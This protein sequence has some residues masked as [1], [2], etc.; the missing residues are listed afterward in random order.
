M[1]RGRYV[2]KEAWH[3]RRRCAWSLESGSA[4]A[5]KRN[6]RNLMHILNSLHC[7]NNLL[8]KFEKVVS[9]N[10]AAMLANCSVSNAR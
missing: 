6:L 4:L 7:N 10:A 1:G 8:R 5:L 2:W 9:Q 3:C